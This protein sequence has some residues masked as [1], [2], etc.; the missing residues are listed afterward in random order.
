MCVKNNTQCYVTMQQINHILGAIQTVAVVN[1][2][3]QADPNKASNSF[4]IS[5][6]DPKIRGLARK[7]K[8]LCSVHGPPAKA[9]LRA[10]GGTCEPRKDAQGSLPMSCRK[11]SHWLLK[12]CDLNFQKV[13]ERNE[14]RIE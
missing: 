1:K 13:L 3:V 4:T 8:T 9:Q 11:G 6:Q 14:A 2:E 12:S 10:K 5:T 7:G